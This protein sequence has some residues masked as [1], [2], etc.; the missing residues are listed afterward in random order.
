MALGGVTIE[1]LVDA[2]EQ[3]MAARIARPGTTLN[4][5]LSQAANPIRAR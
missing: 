1:V 5:A 2:V 4:R 3:A